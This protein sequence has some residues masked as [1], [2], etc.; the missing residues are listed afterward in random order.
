MVSVCDFEDMG[1]SVFL[2]FIFQVLFL[3]TGRGFGVL[4]VFGVADRNIK[5]IKN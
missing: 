3:E 1:F 2:L 4:G 5:K